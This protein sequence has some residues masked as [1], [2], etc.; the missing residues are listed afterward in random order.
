MIVNRVLVQG[1]GIGGLVAA[2][3][4]ARRGVEVDVVERRPA[5][6]V[7]GVGLNQPSNALRVMDEIGVL[8]DCLAAGCQWDDLRMIGA[9]GT[10]LAEIPP[11]PAPGLP[12]RNNGIQRRE[13][14]RVLLDAA[15]KAGARLHHDATTATVSAD[16][17]GVEVTFT[18]HDAPVPGRY[19]LVAGFD[20]I[21]SATRRQL[22]GD[23]Y[24]PRLTGFSVWRISLPR[25]PELD[26][27]VYAF[28]GKVKATLIPL[29]SDD[30]YIALVAPEETVQQGMTPPHIAAQMHAMLQEFGGWIGGLAKHISQENSA[31]YGPIEQVTLD[32]PWYRGRVLIAGDAAHATSPHMAQGAAMAAED[33]V[34]LAE[35]LERATSVP[36]ALGAWWRRR[37]P[38]AGLVQDY[39]AA[40]MRQEQGKASPEDLKLLE[41]PI[42]AAH[43]RLA[44]P[45]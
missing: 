45:Y 16:G 31:A 14:C 42:P 1:G 21:R 15:A 17:D 30:S 18:G 24:E 26:G 12:A 13:L 44:E 4:L 38:R 22:F 40:L 23:R 11:P 9:D 35:E 41:L 39:S 7:L 3:A 33:A 32:E 29:G 34:V 8:D 10:V 19:D 37:I 20:G 28:A 2:T 5:G 43:A 27:V 25:P 6:S 36:E